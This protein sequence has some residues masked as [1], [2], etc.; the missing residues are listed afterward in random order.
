M[1]TNES[2]EYYTVNSDGTLVIN[3]KNVKVNEDGTMIIHDQYPVYCK[4]IEEFVRIVHNIIRISNQEI[5]K[6]K[7]KKKL[8]DEQKE[9]DMNEPHPE[10]ND[11]GK[12]FCP[13]CKSVE[14]GSLRIITHTYECNYGSLRMTKRL[15]E[16]ESES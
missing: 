16:K 3:L 10:L 13:L 8:I 11:K 2:N 14:G 7:E 12:K 1:Q 15:N 9:R 4:S 5:I 6:E